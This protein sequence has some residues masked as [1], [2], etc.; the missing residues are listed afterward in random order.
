MRLAPG[1]R[2]RTARPRLPR[3]PPHVG[4]HRRA[5]APNATGGM[6]PRA[7]DE[8]VCSMA[9]VAAAT[10]SIHCVRG[11]RP[12]GRLRR[13][14]RLSRLDRLSADADDGARLA[15][16]REHDGCDEPNERRHQL[17]DGLSPRRRRV[18]HDLFEVRI[19]RHR[20]IMTPLDSERELLGL[21]RRR[22]LHRAP[23]GDPDL[24]R[25]VRDPRVHRLRLSS[26]R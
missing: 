17:D 21:G 14:G 9:S 25:Q 6:L 7:A 4:R 10:A 12:A 24:P 16:R 2:R 5:H 8:P 19:G 22:E 23:V 18:V 26:G 11:E 20:P 15:V 13:R 1:D 3:S